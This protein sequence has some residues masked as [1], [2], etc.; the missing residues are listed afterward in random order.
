MKKQMASNNPSCGL[1]VM[2]LAFHPDDPGSIPRRNHF[3]F[4]KFFFNK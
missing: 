1:M 2:S 4:D 3:K